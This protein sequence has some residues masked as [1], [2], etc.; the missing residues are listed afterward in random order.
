MQLKAMTR[1]VE[2]LETGN[3]GNALKAAESVETLLSRVRIEYGR[4]KGPEARRVDR[5]LAQL[6]GKTAALACQAA[7]SQVR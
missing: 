5:E 4:R 3:R 2:G 6:V 1:F 7:S